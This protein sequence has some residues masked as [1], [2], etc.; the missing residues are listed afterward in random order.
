M[1]RILLPGEYTPSSVG[2]IEN[3]GW[4]D[5]YLEDVR[6]QAKKDFSAGVRMGEE[7]RKLEK[8]ALSK[9]LASVERQFRQ[10]SADAYMAAWNEALAD[11]QPQSGRDTHV[12]FR[13]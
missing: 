10:E 6:E 7:Y 12:N 3:T 13:I 8:S 4:K 5:G 9:H 11:A 2:A 1:R